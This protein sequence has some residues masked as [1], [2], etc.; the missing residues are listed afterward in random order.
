VSISIKSAREVDLMRAASKIVAN[1]LVD[2]REAV[3]PGMTTRELDR[4]AEGSIKAQGGDPAF[5]YVNDFPGSVCVSVNNEVVHGI[6]GKRRL[7]EGDLVK[8]DVGAIFE[9]YHGDAAITVPV[10]TVSA[11]AR[12]LM[13]VTEQSLAVGIEAAL[14]GNHL[15]DIGAAI[16]D[17]VE[18]RGFSMVR[19]YV[20]HGIGR[21]LHEEPT[22]PHYRQPSR[23]VLL[24]PGM[25]LTI[26]PMV[27]QGTYDTRVL[28]DGWTVVTADGK[29][30]A[31]FEH[32]IVI[33]DGPA[34]I[35][36]VPDNGAAWSIPFQA[37][38]VVH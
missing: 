35:L 11:E 33:S 2:L 30:S 21:E 3:V 12:R 24:R 37:T 22:V 17:Y 34:Q 36:T 4:M 9:G 28:K 26:E 18:P 7:V 32:T 27:N 31:Q 15:N 5:P 10:G 25:A 6:P 8:L 19:Q 38:N 29:L 1:A 23:G 20:G 14:A 13:D 16:Q